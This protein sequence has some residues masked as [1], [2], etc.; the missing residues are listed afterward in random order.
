MTKWSVNLR[1]LTL[2]AGLCAL[3]PGSM[4]AWAQNTNP[5]AGWP[6][7]ESCLGPLP[8][9][10]IPQTQWD[11]EGAIFNANSEGVRAI[12]ADVSTSYFLALEG[13]NVFA[14]AGGFSPDGRYFAYP[15]GSM[16][17]SVNS[18]GDNTYGVD[19]IEVATTGPNPTTIRLADIE[20]IGNAFAFSS[21]GGGAQS[22]ALG[23]IYWVDNER[24]IPPSS[25]GIVNAF[26]ESLESWE[27]N[28]PLVYLRSFSPDFT[29]ALEYNFRE[30]YPPRLYDIENDQIIAELPEAR[31]AL[32]WMPDSSQF[33]SAIQVPNDDLRSQLALYD[34]DGQQL[35]LITPFSGRMESIAISPDGNYFTFVVDNFLFLADVANRTINDLCFEMVHA[36]GSGF[37]R[38]PFARRI[39]WSPDSER[40]AFLY[41]GYPVLL[42]VE[43]NEMQILRFETDHLIQW[44]AVE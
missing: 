9:P 25:I 43:T 17:F 18:F 28:T 39:V 44:S 27:K 32:Y 1:R 10:T 41:D 13:S 29:R 23:Q 7:S 34:R 20:T 31:A 14:E 19:A 42:T 21:A 40:F 33:L 8:Y 35:E 15:I 16:N 3:I 2:A 37:D 38:G 22:S 4:S 12:R 36:S 24:F 11:F 5:A 26:T 30:N 6:V